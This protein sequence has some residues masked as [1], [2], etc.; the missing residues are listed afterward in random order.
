[1]PKP[2]I[3]PTD[4]IVPPPALV[5]AGLKALPAN[6]PCPRRARQPPYRILHASIRNL[7][8]RM[9]YARG[10]AIPRPVRRASAQNWRIIE[11]ITVAAYID[12]KTCPIFGRTPIAKWYDFFVAGYRLCCLPDGEEGWV[13]NAAGRKGDYSRRAIRI[14]ASSPL[15]DLSA[16][17]ERPV[18]C[19]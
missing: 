10:Q 6:H 16:V 13:N 8:I 17:K 5:R 4:E 19:L 12:R 2:P 14:S 3:L 7:N 18:A 9:A 11:P 15:H 1:M